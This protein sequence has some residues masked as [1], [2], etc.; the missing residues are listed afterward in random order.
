MKKLVLFCIFAVAC[1]D[2]FGQVDRLE[3]GY[4]TTRRGI[5]WYRSGLPT[6]SPVWRF[7]RDSS[8]VLWMD[9]LTAVRYD[10][11]YSD[12]VW[13]AKG[14]FT[15]ALPPVPVQASGSTSIDNRSALWIRDT[16]SLL[17][18]YDSTANAWTPHGDFFFLSTVPTEITATGSNGAAKYRRSLW[19]DSDDNKLYYFD[20]SMWTEVGGDLS[21]T[22]EIQTLTAGDGAGDNKTLNLDLGGG[23]VTLDPSGIFTISRS[24]NTLTMDA[25]EVDGSITNE[26]QAITA[27]GTAPNFAVDLSGGGG[28]VGIIQGSNMTISRSGNNLTFAASGGSGLTAAENGLSVAGTT[29]RMGGTLIDAATNWNGNGAKELR[30][31]DGKFSFTTKTGSANSPAQ[32]FRIEGVEALPTT[33]S[34][35]TTDGVLEIR[36]INS[37]GTEQPNSITFGHYPTDTDGSWVQSRSNLNPSFELPL[38]LNPRG[39]Q[40]SV[41]RI[42]GLDALVTLS[43]TGLSG[44]TITGSV[45]HLENSEGNGKAAMSMGVGTDILDSE[46]AW[47]DATDALRLTNRSSVNNTSSIRFAIGGETNDLAALVKSSNGTSNAKL[48]VGVGNPANIHSTVQSAGSFSA[49]PLT[50]VGSFTLDES[51]YLVIYTANSTVTWTLPTAST[52]AGRH[53]ILCNRGSSG[54]VSLS[55]SVS[56]GAGGNFNSLSAGEWA[57]IWSD[58][59][60]WTGFKLTSL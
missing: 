52:C 21:I 32:G 56:K 5:V 35:P 42:G 28:S 22:N 58:G 60:S 41:G 13:R 36:A 16:F 9:T 45:L 34:S 20:G 40:V 46:I 43:G 1:L 15:G 19:Q 55:S 31:Y 4:Q 53:Y 57:M 14:T 24:G 6:T 12:D 39:G 50:T 38:S 37:G 25:T 18:K 48:G 51:N 23:T 10:W 47:F 26:L 27:S 3:L 49:R 54:T 11:D 30:F 2:L 29:V 7:S 8:A 33:N 17:H 44:S 59:S